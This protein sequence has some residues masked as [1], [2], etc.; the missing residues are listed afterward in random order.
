L[1][2]PVLK[3]RSGDE[4]RKGDRVLFHGNP[5]EVDFVASGADDSNEAWYFTESGG[6]IMILDLAVS[7]RTFIQASSL[8]KYEDLEFVSRAA[9]S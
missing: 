7:G 9:E 2:K 5:A 4:I 6:G 3:Y 1:G 8:D